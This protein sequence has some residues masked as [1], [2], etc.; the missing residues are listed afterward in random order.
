[1]EQVSS[2]NFNNKSRLLIGLISFLQICKQ[3]KNTQTVAWQNIEI[4]GVGFWEEL[5]GLG[6]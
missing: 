1:M 3:Y 2:I 4:W 6:T 5:E